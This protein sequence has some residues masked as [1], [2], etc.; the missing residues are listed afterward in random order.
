MAS[1]Y[2]DPAFAVKEFGERFGIGKPSDTHFV[3]FPD[4]RIGEHLLFFGKIG[5]RDDGFR[6]DEKREVLGNV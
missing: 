2:G 6:I 4:F 3:R 1:G 5:L